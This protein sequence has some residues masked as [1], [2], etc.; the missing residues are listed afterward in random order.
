MSK[1]LSKRVPCTNHQGIQQKHTSYKSQ[2]TDIRLFGWIHA[3]MVTV[4]GTWR[5]AIDP[6][7]P[8]SCTGRGSFYGFALQNKTY[9]IISKVGKYRF[10][11]VFLCYRHY[12]L[13]NSTTIVHC[14]SK[15]ENCQTTKETYFVTWTR[16]WFPLHLNVVLD[17]ILV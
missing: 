13:V 10:V 9:T 8:A 16:T 17:N 3:F 6:L 5:V 11:F 14:S 12:Y 7:R 1:H 2:W 4:T 15:H